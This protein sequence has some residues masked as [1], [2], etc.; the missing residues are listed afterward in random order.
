MSNWNVEYFQL[1]FDTH[2]VHVGQKLMNFQKLNYRK[3][4]NSKV[5][6]GYFG[7]TLR[8]NYVT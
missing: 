8:Q 2:I 3:L 7:A 5:K 6:V 4:E 1:S